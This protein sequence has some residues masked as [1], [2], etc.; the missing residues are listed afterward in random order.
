M[1]IKA[2]QKAV[3]AHAAR[4]ASAKGK[5]GVAGKRKHTTIGYRYIIYCYQILLVLANVIRVLLDQVRGALLL[6]CEIVLGLLQFGPEV[7]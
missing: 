5:W 2:L 4:Q 6:L 3:E 1:T 7:L